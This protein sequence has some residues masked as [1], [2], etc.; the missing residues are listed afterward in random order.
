MYSVPQSY[1]YM[2][3]IDF[4]VVFHHEELNKDVEVNIYLPQILFNTVLIAYLKEFKG[5]ELADTDSEDN[6]VDFI[7]KLLGGSLED[8]LDLNF[9]IN[10]ENFINICKREYLDSTFY[11]KDLDRFE[12]EYLD[13]YNFEHGLGIYANED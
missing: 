10:D 5:I 12:E 6:L 2:I 4:N 7:L 1:P 11:T 8:N 3:D 9:L 13:D